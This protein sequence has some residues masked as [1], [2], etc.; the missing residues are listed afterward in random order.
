MISYLDYVKL[1]N[2]RDVKLFDFQIRI[3]Y[4]RLNNLELDNLIQTGGSHDKLFDRFGK[5]ELE[6]MIIKLLN[7]DL[8][9]AKL[10]CK[11]WCQQ[12]LY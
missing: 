5:I 6:N 11:T 4:S 9:G 7:K 8:N 12:I 10:I 3:S 2:D 1:L